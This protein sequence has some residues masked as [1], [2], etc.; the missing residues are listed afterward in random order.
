MTI[1]AG[2]DI[3]APSTT[4]DREQLG[5]SNCL[6]GEVRVSEPGE[7]AYCYRGKLTG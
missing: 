3:T 5:L 6:G 7:G 1:L 2:W 4:G